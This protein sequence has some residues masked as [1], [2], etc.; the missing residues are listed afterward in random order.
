MNLKQHGISVLLGLA[1][2]AGGMSYLGSNSASSRVLAAEH[3]DHDKPMTNAEWARDGLEH[4]RKAH[5]AVNH[6]VNDNMDKKQK[7]Y[8]DAEAAQKSIDN[9]EK[10]LAKYLEYRDAETKK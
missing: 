10:S 7:G 4:L 5:E 1:V 3:A 9:A 2:G 8:S 6:C